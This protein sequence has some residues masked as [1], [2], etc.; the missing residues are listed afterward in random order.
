[1]NSPPNTLPTSPL[2]NTNKQQKTTK[3]QN[4][5]TKQKNKNEPPNSTLADDISRK[6]DGLGWKGRV[7]DDC[8]DDE[9]QDVRKNTGKE[10]NRQISMMTIKEGGGEEE[11][12]KEKEE[13]GGG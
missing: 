8:T 1:M 3:Q 5:K 4:N 10:Y 11:E 7:D 9:D 2:K 12:G 6:S 13:K